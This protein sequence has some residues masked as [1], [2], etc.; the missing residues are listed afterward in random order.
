MAILDNPMGALL[1][2][3]QQ[4]RADRSSGGTD[5]RSRRPLECLLTNCDKLAERIEAADKK[6]KA[7]VVR[8]G[9]VGE[10]LDF[11]QL[12]ADVEDAFND[13]MQ[14]KSKFKR[15]CE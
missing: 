14:L 7:L 10:I 9:S 8:F 6:Y 4:G 15:C 2:V 3:E 5:D 13:L 1:A 12:Q 11:S